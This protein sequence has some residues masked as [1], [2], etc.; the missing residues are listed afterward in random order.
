M[1]K[2]V[3]T[4]G[5]VNTIIVASCV[6][7]GRC[8]LAKAS[9]LDGTP[10]IPLVYD[11]MG[12]R[13]AITRSGSMM[14][15]TR[16]D[17]YGYND[18]NELVSETTES[19][20]TRPLVLQRQGGWNFFYT[21]DMRPRRRRRVA[22]RSVATEPRSGRKRPRNKNVSDVV[23]FQQARGVPAH[24]EYAPFG[25]VTA[26]TTNTA[27]TA[28]NVAETNPYRFSSEYSDDTLG[29]VYYNYRHC[30]PV[31]G[32]W[33][34]RDFS[35]VLSVAGLYVF[36]MSNPL[37]FYDQLGTKLPS[38][39]KTIA[40]QCCENGVMVD[41]VKV[42]VVN[43]DAT[44]SNDSKS[45]LDLVLPE[46]GLVGYFG[47]GGGCCGKIGF[48][49]TGHLNIGNDWC[50]GNTARKEYLRWHISYI[51]EIKVC[52]AEAKKM[53]ETA[54]KIHDDSGTFNYVGHNCSTVGCEIISAGKQKSGGIS[55]IDSPQ[56]LIN[57]IKEKY[58]ATCY[59]GYTL[60]G[61]GSD[62]GLDPSNITIMRK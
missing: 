9:C 43:R 15:E 54:L 11:V 34:N 40:E 5:S 60:A 52:P 53:E 7:G 44:N 17:C 31:M 51:C 22:R 13:T 25:A 59:T 37:V 30:D 50:S 41:K 57:Q 19:V 55:G 49:M 36:C 42:Y 2:E 39:Q 28:F 10:S 45:H 58:G 4:D 3:A 20:A 23:S 27:F 48:G 8:C 46:L 35:E 12:R 21:H 62:G 29:L 33:L 61:N 38:L 24:Y 18:R 47:E 32:R 26:A 6:C 56:N 14:S 1:K 16:T